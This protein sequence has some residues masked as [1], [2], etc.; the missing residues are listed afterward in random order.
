MF[1][2]GR[3]LLLRDW[4]LATST[5]RYRLVVLLLL[6]VLLTLASLVFITIYWNVTYTGTQLYMK[7]RGDLSVAQG[8]L[9]AQSSQRKRA[10]I[11]LQRSWE[12][13]ELLNQNKLTELDRFLTQRQQRLGLTFLRYLSPA[14]IRQDQELLALKVSPTNSGLQ[15]LS[16]SQLDRLVPELSKQAELRIVPTLMAAEPESSGEYRGLV[17]RSLVPVMDENGYILGA[18]DGGMLLNH[19]SAYVDEVRDLVYTDDALPYDVVGSVSL[20][21]DNT[22]I[23]T[24]ARDSDSGKRI[25]G[26]QVSEAVR[27]KVLRQG[28]I[29]VG[30]SYEYDA[31]NVSAYMP[32]N[33]IS[34]NRI[35][36][37]YTGFV[38]KAFIDTYLRNIIELGG[39]LLV[40]LII[41]SWAVHRGAA[42]LLKPIKQISTVV[43]AV[44]KGEDLRIGDL[45]LGQRNELSVLAQQFDQM[46]DQLQQRNRQIQLANDQLEQKVRERTQSLQDLT[47]E[48]KQNIDLL[49]TTR[50]Q[51]VTNEKL[52]ALG[53]M[54]AGIAHEINNPTA[55]IL[56]N[57]EL[58]KWELGD[59]ASHVEEEIELI[60]QQVQRIKMI[61]QSLLQYA[62]PGD[63]DMPIKRQAINPIIDE[64]LVLVRHSLSRQSVVVT[65]DLQATSEAAVNRQQLL[66]VL[67]N[68][69]VNAAH[70]MDGNGEVRV[71]TKDWVE[72]DGSTK[73]VE[74]RVEDDGCGIPKELQ[75]RIFDP[76][77][78]TRKQGTGL[79]LSLSYGIIRRFGGGFELESEPD[80][81][82]VFTVKLPTE[83]PELDAPVNT[84]S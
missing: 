4:Q 10:L 53:E 20:F 61:I 32:L 11:Q 45:G 49:N 66:Q 30:R 75:S 2:R 77:F 84:I 59:N 7:V 81:G 60:F 34:G 24:N 15:V 41:S 33:D 63:M 6:P 82:T 64:M 12:F 67:I 74:V 22:R 54:T 13:R 25:V 58:I 55:V 39:A 62:R 8:V 79:G 28:E 50:S 1:N 14:E 27:Q 51:M 44:E 31:W 69:V 72:A 52:V 42:G 70:A 23:S 26:S 40:I 29:W 38:E 43:N 78:T 83:S 9:E 21:L 35:G 76:F 36:M 18:L 48:L 16:A 5:V 46:L 71:I 56:G 37:L 57:I 68:L 47:H 3:T 17:S 19:E 73:G 65:L 80:K